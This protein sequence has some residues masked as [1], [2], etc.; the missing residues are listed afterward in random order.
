MNGKYIITGTLA[1]I[2]IIAW[3]LFLI[4]RDDR[5][6]RSYYMPNYEQVK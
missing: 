1:F 6:F 3:N 4:Q 2:A 5:M